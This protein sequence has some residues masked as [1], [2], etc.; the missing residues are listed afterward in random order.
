MLLL[1]KILL[2]SLLS[3]TLVVVASCMTYTYTD[4]RQVIPP[5]R[6]IPETP[7]PTTKAA[8]PTKVMEAPPLPDAGT[9]PQPAPTAPVET[10]TAALVPLPYQASSDFLDR[11][12]DEAMNANLDILGFTGE[13]SA[14][15]HIASRFPANSTLLDTTCLLVTGLEVLD[16]DSPFVVVGFETGKTL[17][18]ALIDIQESNVFQNLLNESTEE[19]WS[20][21]ILAAHEKRKI[22]M[23][24]L[25]QFA[26]THPLL[27]LASL[28]EP[29]GDDWFETAGGHPYRIPFAWP[30]ADLL[31]EH[32]FMDSW[33]LTH[34]DA[35]SAPG[36]TWEYTTAASRFT[37]RVDFLM[38]KGLL[39]SE[40]HTVP[41]GPWE[42]KR[43]PREQRSAVTGTFI[44]P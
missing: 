30:M 16:I 19:A 6:S 37:E 10:F 22:R 15:A 29:S 28:G 35:E 27:V 32:G 43:F 5:D 34:Y 24:P 4:A 21:T 36:T 14:I 3:T 7:F 42:T 31:D 11:I 26:G 40:T 1:K 12:V 23:E 44:V 38:V 8:L 41:I 13:D 39:P 9:T 20:N 25:V 33:R 18:V 2:A 17:S